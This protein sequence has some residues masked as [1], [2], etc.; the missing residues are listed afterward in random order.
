MA[1][2]IIMFTKGEVKMAGYLPIFFF[3]HGYQLRQSAGQ[4]LFIK[5]AKKSKANIQAFLTEQS[6]WSII[7]Q[8]G[9][10]HY[11]LEEING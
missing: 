2:S 11:F 1:I 7:Y 3:L 10:E 9:K 8:M 5:H 6:F 4:N